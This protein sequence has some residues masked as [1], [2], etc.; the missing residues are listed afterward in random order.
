MLDSLKP[1]LLW[2]AVLDLLGWLHF[3]L[4]FR[5]G[6][7][8]RDRGLALAKLVGL[9]LPTYLS[10]LICHTAAPHTQT[11]IAMVVA[12]L[13][14]VN[15]MLAFSDRRDYGAFFRRRWPIVLLLEAVFWVGGI[16]AGWVRSLVPAIAFDP[17]WSGAEKWSDFALVSALSRQWHFPPL[18]PWMAGFPTNYYYYGHLA[19]A[20]LAKL[21]A[22]PPNIAYNVALAMIVAL[23]LTL[24]VSLGYHLFR[25]AG[26]GFLLAWLTVIGGN[27][28]PLAQLIQNRI[29]LGH[30]D[31]HIDFWNASRAMSWGPLGLI[32]GSEIN[33][34]PSFSFI[35]GDLHPH[36]S[37]H[38]LF[39]GFLL[40][41]AA[42]WRASQR[43]ILLAREVV[44][45]RMA[46]WLALAFLA[47][48]LY[49]TNS[50]DCFV[51][52]FLAAVT[53]PFARGFRRWSVGGRMAFGLFVL[54]L[55][56]VAATRLLFLP[57]DLFFIPPKSFGLDIHQ[58]PPISAPLAWVPVE[59]RTTTVQWLFY[60]GLFALPYLAWQTWGAARRA[61]L[62]P[63]DKK[64]AHLS[65]A[66]AAGLLACVHGQQGLVGWLA[67][68][69]VALA[70][71]VFHSRRHERL[72]L[73]SIL[74]WCGLLVSFLCEW[75][76]YDDAFSGENERINTIF[77]VYY[78]LWPVAALAAVGAC[79]A[80]WGGRT[81][82]HKALRR[83]AAL[84][85]M[86]LLLAVSA[87]YP[88]FGWTTRVANY[89]ESNIGLGAAPTLDG[90]RYLE[91]LP[92]LSDDYRA[93]L[94]LRDHASPYAVVAEASEWGYSAAGRFAAIGGV[95][96]L[97]GWSQHE[98]VWR[99]GGGWQWVAMRKQAV[100]D[101]FTTTSL[102]TA[103]QILEKN[104][105]D[106]VAVGS[107]ERRLYPPEGLSKFELL[108]KEVFRS[109]QT[110][111]YGVSQTAMQD[112][113][114]SGGSP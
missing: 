2:L 7:L 29:E 54:I 45:S 26:L 39:L 9:F 23:A 88:L 47:G 42:L 101:L 108:G 51:G 67:F 70:P 73:V 83:V 33:E 14:V 91:T 21:T 6:R 102:T 94:W 89:R 31:P 79:S 61:G 59:L 96:C 43:E 8:L 69:L 57:F 24:C 80:L 20:T 63:L 78:C 34:F 105:V 3:P 90:L 100:N 1:V 55:P 44:A 15:G 56:Y 41:L 11:T 13:A 10:W 68:A 30:F 77:K 27:V 98:S 109:G 16:A 49:T 65:L 71:H 92:G 97:L 95:T 113:P 36:F 114:T 86:A 72:G 58:W 110:T 103:L 17:N 12:T 99:E 87:L 93:G 48:L 28:K 104:D 37:A 111:L 25:S 22:T 40:I 76:Y 18:D 82:P 107:L 106:F 35:L 62:A 84:T 85:L 64:T 74:A 66:L 75:L 5:L 112:R 50:W 46:Q 52:L 38:P 60:F 81:A 19:W 53:L 4:C 32:Q